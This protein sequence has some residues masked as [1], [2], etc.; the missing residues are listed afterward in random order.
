MEKV[1]FIGVYDKTDCILY[2]AKILT[3]VGKR[4]LVIDSTLVQKTRYLVPVLGPTVAYVTDFEDIDV[5]V[6]FKSLEKIKDY[7]GVPKESE[8]DYDYALIDIDS[9]EQMQKFYVD[10]TENNYFVSGFDAYSIKRGLEAF[11][12]LSAPLNVTKVSYSKEMLKEEDDYL[13]FLSS[14]LNINWKESI[15]Y[16]PVEISDSLAI[17][18]NQRIQKLKF[19]NLSPQYKDSILYIAEDILKTVK[20]SELRKILKNIEKL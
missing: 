5:A 9:P 4:V 19:R 15:I 6:G 11:C 2:V 14:N 18:E 1:N 3:A 10:S 13:N 7:L 17:A 8:L 20:N 12:N 16:F